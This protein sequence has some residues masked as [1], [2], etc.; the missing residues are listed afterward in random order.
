MKG[1]K[2]WYNQQTNWEGKA[3]VILS[4]ITALGIIVSFGSMMINGLF[5]D[6]KVVY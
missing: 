3:S 1:I 5:R 2:E 6:D 4:C